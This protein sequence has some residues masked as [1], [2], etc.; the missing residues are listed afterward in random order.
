MLLSPTHAAAA[1]SSTAAAAVGLL[2]FGITRTQFEAHA[3]RVIMR[4]TYGPRDHS[5]PPMD[6]TDT[7]RALVSRDGT[8]SPFVIRLTGQ[9]NELFGDPCYGCVDAS[10]RF[11]GLFF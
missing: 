2:P 9:H 3:K 7:V 4:A 5:A 6:V 1:A 8:D 10:A 11:G